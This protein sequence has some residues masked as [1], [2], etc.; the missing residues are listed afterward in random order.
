M[1]KMCNWQD[2][3]PFY[4]NNGIEG[5][6]LYQKTEGEILH[7]TLDPNATLAAH[8]SPVDIAIYVLAGEPTIEIGGTKEV[9]Q[10]GTL[11]ECAKDVK[12]AIYNPR[13]T[14]VQVLVIKTPKP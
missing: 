12:H 6:R 8:S 10:V 3:E 11:V 2:V 9:C 5:R 1:I 4:T 13:E 14:H 7:L